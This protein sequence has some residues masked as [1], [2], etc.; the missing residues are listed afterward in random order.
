MR[1]AIIGIGC[2]LIVALATMFVLARDAP[3]AKREPP[4]PLKEIQERGV[5]G[6]L[7]PRLGTI[8]EVSGKVVPNT[9]RAKVDVGEPF[10]LRIEQVDGHTLEK[11]LPY[12][13][14]AMP[15]HREISGLKV[16][17]SFRCVGYESGRFEGLAD[18]ESKYV[19]VRAGQPFHLAPQFEV[20]KVISPLRTKE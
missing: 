3:K 5:E 15:L 6:R 1:S 20:L 18:G 14:S 12:A 4:V 10:F 19:E 2:L 9:S 17:D 11:P 7:G 8:V 16:G 13:P